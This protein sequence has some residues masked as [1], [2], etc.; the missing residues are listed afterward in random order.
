[1]LTQ[2]FYISL[3]EAT[4]TKY[5]TNQIS[6]IIFEILTDACQLSSKLVGEIY[7]ALVNL[8]HEEKLD[9]LSKNLKLIGRFIK[10]FRIV[11]RYSDICFNV[12]NYFGNN[13]FILL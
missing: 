9:F 3:V 2:D 11:M 10:M 1:M 4:S 13:V 8:G 6:N 12:L 7:K 5:N